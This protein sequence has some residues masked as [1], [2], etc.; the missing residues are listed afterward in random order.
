MHKLF[1]ANNKILTYVSR[2][3]YLALFFA[4]QLL[5]GSTLNAG[6]E[7]GGG[8]AYRCENSH[9]EYETTFLD[10]WEAENKWKIAPKEMNLSFHRSN[11]FDVDSGKL[12]FIGEYN[13]EFYDQSISQY[14]QKTMLYGSPDWFYQVAF[15]YWISIKNDGILTVDERLDAPKDARVTPPDNCEFVGVFSWEDS[16]SFIGQLKVNRIN[17][18]ELRSETQTVA[19]FLHEV[20]YKTIRTYLN[21]DLNIN[22][23]KVVRDLVGCVVYDSQACS[24][25]DK[26][27]F[28]K[29]NLP[30]SVDIL[31]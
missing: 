31:R 16:Q 23:S 13:E 20:I 30:N 26:N 19:G 28:K 6:R 11:S 27:I 1:S 29:L 25:F 2:S 8:G 24:H 9:G 14:L 17:F 4:S 10:L 3:Q 5:V 12:I 22:D 21:K 7:T 15:D 18:F